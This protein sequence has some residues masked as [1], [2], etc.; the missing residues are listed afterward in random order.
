VIS[1]I[2][3]EVRFGSVLH[4]AANMASSLV[5]DYP[6]MRHGY[7]Y[8]FMIMGI[9]LGAILFSGIRT[10]YYI[11]KGFQPN[12]APQMFIIFSPVLGALISVIALGIHGILGHYLNF[13]G[14]WKW[15]LAG[16]SYSSV[17]L[18]LIS[19]W[20]LLFPVIFNPVSLILFFKL[21]R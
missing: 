8:A 1:E 5:I 20:L 17:L 19:P 18:C 9:F 15:F 2:L 11:Y 7:Q 16:I 3:L 21:F 14:Y 10:W 13:N 4:A 12:I 6:T